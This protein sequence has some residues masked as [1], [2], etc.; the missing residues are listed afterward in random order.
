[1]NGWCKKLGVTSAWPVLRGAA[2][3]AH[4]L[5]ERGEGGTGGA[6]DRRTYRWR[7]F[8]WP[9]PLQ[10]ER[11]AAGNPSTM[12]LLPGMPSSTC[13]ISLSL[14]FNLQTVFIITILTINIELSCFSVLKIKTCS[15][16]MVGT[17][18][19]SSY[20]LVLRLPNDMLSGIKRAWNASSIFAKR[21]PMFL[22]NTQAFLP[23]MLSFPILHA[24]ILRSL[25]HAPG[26]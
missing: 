4:R 21:H 3:E 24:K 26:L 12:I 8:A 2:E 13:M 22:L 5:A 6:R 16:I 25:P 15:I 10:L 9:A 23:G 19:I 11:L 17:G 18:I 20:S 14:H 7:R 1:M